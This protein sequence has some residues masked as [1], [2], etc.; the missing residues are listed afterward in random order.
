MNTE[1]STEELLQDIGR[2][3]SES[4]HGILSTHS[5]KY[6]GY[7]FGSLLPICRDTKGNL[8]LLISHLAQHT[9]NLENDPRCSLTIIEQGGGD[10][11]QL[12][13]L[14]CLAQAEA[15]NSTAAA[16]RYFRFYPDTRRYQK[17][18]NFQFYRLAIKHFYY[19]GGFGS[20]RWF[21]P[22]RIQLPIPFS[23]ADEAELLYQL[24][25]HNHDL[26]RQL[27]DSNGMPTGTAIEAVGCDPSGLDVR[28]AQE[29]KRLQ[30]KTSFGDKSAYLQHIDTT[31][32]DSAF[33]ST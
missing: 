2:I 27:L 26:L 18:L 5:L 3:W 17:E 23:T 31:N 10:V 8:M 30:F 16:E 7:P 24:N 15:V 9:R 6:Q 20:A 1:S 32:R 13:R 12:T 14:T 4:Y 29:L 28:F 22:S 33:P 11:Q 19:I 21:D 25:S